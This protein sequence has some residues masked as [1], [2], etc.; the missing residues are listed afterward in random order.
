MGKAECPKCGG[1]GERLVDFI[2][3][4]GTSRLVPCTVCGGGGWLP[5]HRLR[6]LLE[7]LELREMRK[8]GGHTLRAAA[9]SFG[10]TAT[11]LSY[12]EQGRFDPGV[13]KVWGTIPA[14]AATRQQQGQGDKSDD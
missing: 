2:C 6:W 13:F 4:G 1:S 8:R 7:G 11:Y 5:P 10:V 9:H 3:P 14:H 12:C